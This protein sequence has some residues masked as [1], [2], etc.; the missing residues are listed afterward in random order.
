M[1]LEASNEELYIPT[2]FEKSETSKKIEPPERND[3][4]LRAAKI[5]TE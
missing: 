5:R 1:I 4:I 2:D 3:G